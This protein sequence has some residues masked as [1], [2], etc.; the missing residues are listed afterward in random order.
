[1]LVP[2]MEEGEA[3]TGDAIDA[4]SGDQKCSFSGSTSSS[5]VFESC[6]PEP[7]EPCIGLTPPSVGHGQGH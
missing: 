2:A 6:E 5:N 7:A 4:E 3:G 1:M